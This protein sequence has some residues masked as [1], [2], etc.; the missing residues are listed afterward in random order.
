MVDWRNLRPRRCDL[1][2]WRRLLRRIPLRS[3]PRRRHHDLR[4]LRSSRRRRMARRR[5]GHARCK[6]S[7]NGWR[8]RARTRNGVKGGLAGR[9]QR[10]DAGTPTA[11]FRLR[12]QRDDRSFFMN[13]NSACTL[14]E[15]C[16]SVC[17]TSHS[18]TTQSGCG[19]STSTKSARFCAYTSG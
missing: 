11:A 13:F 16:R 12:S 10:V 5:T 18:G 15:R 4:R 1:H 14:A 3:T 7:G 6:Q 8:I 9:F 17:V 19:A 2:Q